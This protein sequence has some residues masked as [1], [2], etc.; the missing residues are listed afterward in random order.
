MARKIYSE[1]QWNLY[2][3]DKSRIKIQQ[4][5][6]RYSAKN[7]NKA[8]EAGELKQEQK[9]LEVRSTQDSSMR[10][11]TKFNTSHKTSDGERASN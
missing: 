5:H 4:L 7:E 10:R 6:H 1:T 2:V 3:N 8:P 11:E 9:M